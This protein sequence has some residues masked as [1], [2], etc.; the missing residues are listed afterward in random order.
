MPTYQAVTSRKNPLIVRMA[1]LSDKNARDA[2]GLFRLDGIKLFAEAVK[3]GVKINYAFA[4][5][6]VLADPGLDF[7]SCGEVF[8][9]TGE[10]LDRLTDEKAPQG[11]VTVAQKFKP[12]TR[13][14]TASHRSLLLSSIRDP[15]N[16]GTIIRSA[17]AF[18]LDMIYLS[19]DCAD[20]FSPKTLRASMGMLFSQPFEIVDNE[21]ELIERLKR[22]GCAVYAAALG[23]D[24]QRL[25][26]LELP[27]RV[28]FAVGNEGHGLSEELI[29]A[30]T[31]CVIIPME[32]GCESLNAAGAA[33][34]L[35]WEMRGK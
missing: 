20:V 34:I 13:P 4:T 23:R 17:R 9:V 35:A 27:K 16:V 33:G 1:K 29:D 10:V 31:G 30:C 11:I 15:G 2:E 21:L 5:R 22:E 28:C 25:G 18:G 26:E 19:S 3:N 14:Q 8:E 24:A 32:E 6:E 12:Q 7:S